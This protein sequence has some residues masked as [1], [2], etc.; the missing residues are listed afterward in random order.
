MRQS[1]DSIKKIKF[2]MPEFWVSVMGLLI[3]SVIFCMWYCK[4]LQYSMPAKISAVFS[5]VMYAAV[6][7]RFVPCWMEFWKPSRLDGEAITTDIIDD[8]EPKYMGLKIFVAILLWNGAVVLLVYLIRLKLGYAGSF[9]DGII[10][11]NC[12]D[13]IHYLDIARDWYLSEGVWDRLVQLVFLPGYPLAIRFVNLFINNY[14]YSGMIVSACSFAGAGCV[15]YKLL[16]LDYSHKDA[17]RTIRFLCLLPGAFFFTAPMSESLFLFLCVCCIYFVR[18]DRWFLGC[19]FGA[20]A[21][22]TRSLGLVLCVPLFF[23]LVSQTIRMWKSKTITEQIRRLALRFAILML[24]PAGFGVYCFINYL[25]SGDFFQFMEYQSVHWHQNLGWFFNT[26]SYQMEYAVKNW[27]NNISTLLGLWLPNLTA[28]FLSL[29]IMIL[30]VKKLRPSYTAWFLV[31][32]LIAMGATWLLSA[33]R[34]LVALL[35]IPLAMSQLSK[36]PALNILL[37]ILSV[38]LY[39]IYLYAFVQGWNVW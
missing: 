8:R 20:M 22:F 31:Y 37:T 35:P 9:M 30:A 28:G 15:T 4:N 29:G 19:L 13:G 36:K 25:V 18:K 14:L 7:L 12:A 16:R 1:V 39:L 26:A 10:F 34:Y 38:L 21:A 17:I 5:V 6:C 24:V 11:W 33:P 3:L 27:P 23:E 2:I 32:Y